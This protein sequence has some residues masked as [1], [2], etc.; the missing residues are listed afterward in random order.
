MIR[1]Y[2][3]LAWR[4]LIKNKGYS[5]INIG[6]LAIGITAYLLIIQYVNFESRYDQHQPRIDDLYRVTLSTNLG[7]KGFVHAAATHPAVGSAMKQDFP[8]VENFVRVVD[9][10]IML[11]S[12]VLSYTNEQGDLVKSNVSNDKIYLADSTALDLFKINLIKGNPK[13]ALKEQFS[14]IISTKV[15]QRFFGK[16]DPINKTLTANGS[17]PVKITGV[18]EELPENTHLKFDMLISFSSIGQNMDTV[19]NWPEFYNYI[20]LRPGTDPATV[21]AKFPDFVK[22]YLSEIMQEHSFEA[23]MGL[24]PVKDIHLKSHLSNEISVNSNEKTL[25]F[26]WLIAVFVILIALMNFINLSTAKSTERAMEVG[27][28]K[29]VGIGRSALIMQFLFESVIINL[30]AAIIA[31]IIITTLI[32]PFN[33]F[34]GLHILALDMWLQPQIWGHIIGLVFLGG[35]LAGI[36]PAFVLSGF[37]PIQVLKGKFHQSE[38]GTLIRKALVVI[39]FTISIALIAGTFIMYS[40]FAYMQNQDLGFDSKH[41]LIVNAPMVVDSTINKKLEVFKAELLRNPNINVVTA[42]ADIP[43]KKNAWYNTT[44]QVHEERE[45]SVIC[46]QFSID[47]DFMKTYQIKL[48]AGR[49]FRLEDHSFYGFRGP[50]DLGKHNRVMVNRAAVKLLGYS[51]I[52]AAVNKKIIFQLGPEDRTAEIIGVMENYH[53]QS[54][55]N[56]YDPTVFLYPSYYNAEYLTVNINASNIESTIKAIGEKYETF[57]PMDPYDYFFLD[58]HFN[59]QYKADRKFGQLFFLFAGLAIFIAALGLFGLGS[60]MAMRRTKELCVRKV[61]GAN[62]L[63]IL[64]LIPKSLLILVFI[65]GVIAIPITYFMASEWLS[66]Y[67]FRVDINLWMFMA[68]LIVVIIVAA[69]SVLP[70]SIKVALVKPANYLRNE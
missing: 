21:E 54:L 14:I 32:N 48:L 51:S 50:E 59:K 12:F 42:T 66:N 39:Q 17:V 62:T 56:D 47:H 23:R 28:K 61:L 60:Y 57:F 10:E 29:V 33:E 55:Q 7:S 46:N 40:Q 44:R 9:K 2:F 4:N 45:A 36:Y 67:A 63:R 35:L 70:E 5:L 53:Q 22:K 52:E 8:E 20:R 15:A 6:G 58:A 49:N 37:K 11:G 13:T 25:N 3:K 34:V 24:Q 31:L 1:N 65:S 43:G 41:N 16:E 64:L 68:P 19:W 69:L 26:L 18:F 27:L 30:I 38:K